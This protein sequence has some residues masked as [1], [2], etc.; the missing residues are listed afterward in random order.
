MR[1]GITTATTIKPNVHAGPGTG[2]HAREGV[3]GS[4]KAE[5]QVKLRGDEIR[6]ETATGTKSGMRTGI[7]HFGDGC[8][9]WARRGDVI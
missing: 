3:S 8:D 9:E 4:R 2:E 1:T 5:E 6:T 7:R